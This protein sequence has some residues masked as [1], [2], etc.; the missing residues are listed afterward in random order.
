MSASSEPVNP[1]VHPKRRPAYLQDYEVDLQSF[2]K[3]ASPVSM[4]E[5]PVESSDDYSS[6]QVGASATKPQ[7]A[8][9]LPTFSFPSRLTVRDKHRN[10]P[11]LLQQHISS[12]DHQSSPPYPNRELQSESNAEFVPLVDE[13][14]GYQ[15]DR[16]DA[17]SLKLQRISEE[18]LKLRETQQAIQA[19]LKRIETAKDELIQVLDRAFSLQ[20]PLPT[21]NTQSDHPSVK[22]QHAANLGDEDWP[23]PPPPIAYDEPET[24]NQCGK[25]TFHSTTRATPTLT[26]RLTSVEKTRDFSHPSSY[27]DQLRYGQYP[28]KQTESVEIKLFRS[29]MG[30]IETSGDEEFFPGCS[31]VHQKRSEAE[32]SCVSV[33]SLWSSQ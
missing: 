29:I 28:A 31:S 13:G 15:S 1:S 7:R 4:R 25:Q 9:S 22:F 20:R 5:Q 16:S 3:S 8:H 6:S 26:P 2:R 21:S 10:H 14:D 23:E 27:D 33:K 24:M 19:D 17:S 11:S 18:N 30:K 32:S 12:P